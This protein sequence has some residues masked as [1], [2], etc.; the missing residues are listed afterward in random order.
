MDAYSYIA[1]ADAAAIETLYQAYRQNPESV[2]FGWRKFFEGFDFSQQFPEGASVLPGAAPAANATAIAQY[3]VSHKVETNL[4]Q[5]L[6][7]ARASA[8]RVL[9]L[10][11]LVREPARTELSGDI[12]TVLSVLGGDFAGLLNRKF[13]KPPTFAPDAATSQF[14]H[15][16]ADH[17]VIRIREAGSN[18]RLRVHRLYPY[19]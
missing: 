1:N 14:L 16:M 18:G 19:G 17:G 13:P 8:N 6:D 4:T 12:A 2:D 3:L 11:L 5:V 9:L 10:E 15:L 7:L